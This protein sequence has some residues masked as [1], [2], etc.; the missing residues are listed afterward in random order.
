MTGGECRWYS[1]EIHNVWSS[2]TVF[3]LRLMWWTGHLADMKHM[4]NEY[5]CLPGH[6]GKQQIERSVS[7][8]IFL[9][10]LQFTKVGCEPVGWIKVVQDRLQV[11]L[12]LNLQWT[13]D[14]NKR[15]GI[16]VNSLKAVT[17]TKRSPHQVIE[18]AAI[19]TQLNLVQLFEF[20]RQFE[21]RNS[22]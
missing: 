12:F 19:K 2:V 13:F 1:D 11:W 7:N 20:R 22:T 17:F 15:Q 16:L 4:R 3:K 6:E 9:L 10:T 5:K 8:G 18:T 21:Q 14:F